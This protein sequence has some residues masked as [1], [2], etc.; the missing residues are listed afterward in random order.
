MP[1]FKTEKFGPGDQS[2]LGSAHGIGNART[3][4]MDTADFSGKAED[5]VIPSG[6][7]LALVSGQLKPYNSA[8]GDDTAKLVG[9]L[10][11]DQ[12]VGVGK[13]GVAVLDHGRVRTD[14]L[15]EAFTAPSDANNLTTIVFVNR[16]G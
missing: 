15:P 11:T 10:M 4:W 9:F 2:W 12:P 7:A 14:R 3:E 8:G 5:G 16:E 6:T 13:I 1:K